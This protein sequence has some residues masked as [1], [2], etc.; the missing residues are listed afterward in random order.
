MSL[1]KEVKQKIIQDFA[2]SEK[3]TGSSPVQIAV[4]TEKIK[5]LTEHLKIHKHDF[6]SR[7]GL[8]MM[9]G[10]RKRLLNYFS[11]KDPE[12]CAKLVQTLGIRFKK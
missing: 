8:L 3:D 7:R 12:A 6:H 11:K 5:D 4:L 9:V 10:K 2:Q 1:E